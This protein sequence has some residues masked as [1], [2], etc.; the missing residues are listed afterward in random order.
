MLFHHE[1]GIPTV[2]QLK[3][4]EE[5]KKLVD[6]MKNLYKC[7]FNKTNSRKANQT[8][9]NFKEN[10]LSL[11]FLFPVMVVGAAPRD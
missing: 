7:N 10:S 3:I 9:K 6:E 8:I 2:R 11:H 1:A 4:I 5:V